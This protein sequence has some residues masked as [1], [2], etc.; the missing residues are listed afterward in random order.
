[1]CPQ[2]KIIETGDQK[3]ITTDCAPR[4]ELYVGPL[5]LYDLSLEPVFQEVHIYEIEREQ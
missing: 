4:A 3:K 5:D 1:M 2:N